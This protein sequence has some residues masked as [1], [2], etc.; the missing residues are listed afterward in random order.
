[1]YIRFLRYGLFGGIRSLYSA[2][3]QSHRFQLL[4]PET[5]AL[6]VEY[7]GIVKDPVQSAEQGVILIEITALV[8]RVLVAGEHNIEVAFLVVS[9]VNQIEE[10]PGI[11]FVKF[12]MPYLVNNQ[13]GR[14]YQ[15]IEY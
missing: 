10:Q 11:L 3:L 14:P 5:L 1:M 7:R 2:G 13:A 15:A 6:N 12:T 8:G 9:P 4:A